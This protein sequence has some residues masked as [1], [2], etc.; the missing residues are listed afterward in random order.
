MP[1]LYKSKKFYWLN[2]GSKFPVREM[3]IWQLIL[4]GEIGASLVP[5][6]K[7]YSWEKYFCK[8]SRIHYVK[9][10][11][12]QTTSCW[13]LLF[14]VIKYEFTE[15][16]LFLQNS[17]FVNFSKVGYSLLEKIKFRLCYFRVMASFLCTAIN[18]NLRISTCGFCRT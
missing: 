14:F 13:E 3:T 17:G 10:K 2:H 8:D 1:N 11:F 12:G 16:W 18:F 4:Q 5:D 15:I 6:R 9:L 7:K